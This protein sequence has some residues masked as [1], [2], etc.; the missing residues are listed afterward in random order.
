MH[1]N[2]SH[3]LELS[4]HILKETIYFITFSNT[5]PNNQKRMFQLLKKNLTS[6]VTLSSFISCCF[7]FNFFVCWK[8]TCVYYNTLLKSTVGGV[9]NVFF[10]SLRYTC[11]I[12]YVTFHY[13][14]NERVQNSSLDREHKIILSKN[15]VHR[16]GLKY[17][18]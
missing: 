3:T 14:N 11:I 1:A 5:E 9:L 17:K 8:K 18:N 12:C 16:N 13:N 4:L 2:P 15:Y 6:Y 7:I 10:L